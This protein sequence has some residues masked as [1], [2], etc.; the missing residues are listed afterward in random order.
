[1]DDLLWWTRSF[2][3]NHTLIGAN[4]SDIVVVELV[5]QAV[6]GRV[7]VV[8][9]LILAHVGTCGYVLSCQALNGLAS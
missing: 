6:M 8:E 5:C 4:L 9:C 7:L 1:M 3:E 2:L